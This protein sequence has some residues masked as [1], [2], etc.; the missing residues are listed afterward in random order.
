MF[1]PRNAA[2]N[3]I[4]GAFALLLMAGCPNSELLQKIGDDLGID[5]SSI[6]EKDVLNALK[7]VLDAAEARG[8]ADADEPADDFPFED[9]FEFFGEDEDLFDGA[10]PDDIEVSDQE[11]VDE[12][13]TPDGGR[14][15]AIG[16][17]AGR[18]RNDE[19][20]SSS[21]TSP[22]V[23]RGR[24]FDGDDN[25]R[26][27][28]RGVYR[29]MPPE[30]LPKELIGGGKFHGKIIGPEGR[31]LGRLRG[32]YGHARDGSG[33]FYGRWFDRHDR[34]IG[35]LKGYWRDEEG[36]NGGRFAGRW[37]AFSVCAE[38]DSLPEVD[39]EKGDFGGVDDADVELE[40]DE[41]LDTDDVDLM[42]EPDVELADER[43]KSC[44]APA[45]VRG[46]VRGRHMP[47]EA[48]AES[49][50]E[51]EEGGWVRARMY[52]ADGEPVGAIIGRWESKR[53]RGPD[54]RD[55]DADEDEREEN[56]EH[57][58][59]TED[60]DDRDDLDADDENDE[61]AGDAD[62]IK[63]PRDRRKNRGKSRV[64]GVF[65]GKYV[66]LEGNFRGFVRG[67]WG[68]GHHGVG[69]FHG[70]Y[71]SGNGEEKGVLRG[72]WDNHP[73][74]PGGPMF[75]VWFGLDFAPDADPSQDTTDDEEMAAEDEAENDQ[76]DA[77][78]E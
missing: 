27:V 31:F 69:A 32:R 48:D 1:R 38:S 58:A 46:L 7:T 45:H 12:G 70:R 20:D 14:P 74:Q 22:G 68:K 72:R 10:A 25:P 40:S 39:F 41:L 26:G 16:G 64:N 59:D 57:E 55:E 28:V 13:A 34:L 61:Q 53:G 56:D 29:P 65:Y 33:M 21:D 23:F 49:D 76:E 52:D 17:L 8:Y 4:G 51:A 42:D 37:T 50:A 11:A 63:H 78:A 36:Q 9:E 54:G 66:D 19:P 62:E 24:W 75:G 15:T 77:P 18:F 2:R 44:F 71:F 30:S 43:E 73:E 60:A 3:A 67:V 35:A 47:F 6:S 5:L